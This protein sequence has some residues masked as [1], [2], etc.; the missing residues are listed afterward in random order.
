[1]PEA[2][3]APQPPCGAQRAPAPP[4]ERPPAPPRRHKSA[5]QLSSLQAPPV[6][7]EQGARRRLLTRART[8]LPHGC[9][10]PS[11]R[12]PCTAGVGCRVSTGL[13]ACAGGPAPVDMALGALA[14]SAAADVAA[15]ILRPDFNQL[16]ARRARPAG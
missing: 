3:R 11:A 15:L 8:R 14:G 4:A 1:M 6:L 10:C 5:A 13:H 7:Q 12:S 16:Q 9:A 2:L